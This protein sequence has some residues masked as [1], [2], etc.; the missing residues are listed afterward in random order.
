MGEHRFDDR[1]GCCKPPAGVW[2]AP[3]EFPAFLQE[4]LQKKLKYEFLFV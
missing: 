1:L 3:R 4:L 2:Q